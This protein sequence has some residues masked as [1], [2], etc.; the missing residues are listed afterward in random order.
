MFS[1]IGGADYSGLLPAGS[2]I[3]MREYPNLRQ[4]GPAGQRCVLTSNRFCKSF[5][6]Y[7]NCI[8]H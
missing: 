3:N 7:M 5:E 8:M 2:Y 4:L 1:F 6:S